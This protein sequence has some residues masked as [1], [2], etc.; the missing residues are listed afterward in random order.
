MKYVY[1]CTIPCRNSYQLPTFKRNCCIMCT[2]VCVPG[3]YKYVKS[4][5][6]GLQTELT[7]FLISII[8][9]SLS[10]FASILYWSLDQ[11]EIDSIVTYERI[12]QIIYNFGNE[13]SLL[14]QWFVYCLC[15]CMFTTFHHE[16]FCPEGVC[17]S[18]NE[19][20]V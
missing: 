16:Y 14:L 18:D 8:L 3:R 13:L 5:Y 11:R 10:L 2:C 6:G 19:Q 20:F 7:I 12:L 9:Q 1:L 4:M 17:A 15:I